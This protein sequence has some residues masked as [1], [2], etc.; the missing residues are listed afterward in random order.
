MK[1][2]LK[3]SNKVTI[4]LLSILFLFFIVSTVNAEININSGDN[5]GQTI[6]SASNGDIINLNNGTY[7]NNV[8][9]ITIDKNLTIQGKDRANTI[10]DAQK[11]G[12][13]F[14]ITPDNT[15]T[16][17]N[18]TL[19]N[20][21]DV[22][23][24]TIYNQGSLTINNVLFK[25]NHAYNEGGAIY[26][27]NSS[28]LYIISCIFYGN[29]ADVA[30]GGISSKNITNTIISNCSFINN[31]APFGGAISTENGKDTIITGSSFTENLATLSIPGFYRAGVLNLQESNSFI[32]GCDFSNNNWGYINSLSI[33]IETGTKIT[34]NYNRFFNNTQYELN[35]RGG[36]NLNFDYNWWGVNDITGKIIGF[37]TTNHYI[38]NITN[39]SSLDNVHPGD[40]LNFAL[41]VLNTTLSNDGV[42]N[43]PQF[44]IV[45]TFN[46]VTYNSTNDELF[47]HQFTVSSKGLQ[48]INALLDAQYVS[49]EFNVS[50][51]NLAI[52]AEIPNG[53]VGDIVNA[54]IRLNESIN[55]T[56]DITIGNRTYN[57]VVFIDGIAI[58]PYLI[59]E[60]YEGQL[61]VV[62]VGNEGYNSGNYLVNVLFKANPKLLIDNLTGEV[63]KKIT[64]KTKLL[65]H[66]N[67]PLAGKK[68]NF[69]IK[70]KQ[71]GYAITNS[72]GIAILDYTPIN[73]G[74]FNLEVE[75][76]G[77]N[78]YNPTNALS[79]LKINANSNNNNTNNNETDENIINNNTN[80]N[81]T[82]EDIINNNRN[83]SKNKV[84][85]S[86]KPTGIPIVIFLMITILI[87]AISRVKK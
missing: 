76:A 39:L 52:T 43:L 20:G 50:K 63:G 14:N 40:K 58:I 32:E 66:N 38:L 31:S 16:L 44:V 82:D 1:N 3:I 57:N 25:N 79:I 42:E 51:G 17:T 49:L 5:L 56:S 80:N 33:I 15:L 2:V 53:T 77:D 74:K 34:I 37:N 70:G 19:I 61:D 35:N 12:K 85:A 26:S 62:F 18:I 60:I 86:M 87:F 10:I 75:F 65:D 41:L 73:N 47:I 69:Y 28:N 36:I 4:L 7:T 54:I 59:T 84:N 64:L 29:L 68:I 21:N 48:T 67:N 81:E 8:T 55:T 46:G 72:E 13:I 30:G 23:G 83:N 11:L 9:N 22:Y 24:G 27:I 45:G 6:A 78:Q 71:I